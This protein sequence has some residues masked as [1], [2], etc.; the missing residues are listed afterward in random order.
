MRA[1]VDAAVSARSVLAFRLGADHCRCMA[2]EWVAPLA[3][4]VTGCAGVIFTWLTGHQSR[5]QA[6]DLAIRN[7]VRVQRETAARER[8]DAYIATLR[9]TNLDIQILSYREANNAAKLHEM[10]EVWPKGERYRL[11]MEASI[12]VDAF[13]SPEAVE[14]QRSSN[15]SYA[16]KNLE[17][18]RAHYRGFLIIA[19]KELGNLDLPELP[20]P[21]A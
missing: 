20:T 14:W 2:W 11:A 4:A 5:R 7:E 1:C 13:G 18:M 15:K 19:R 21:A 9:I 16:N 10:D 12:A 8:R 17:E 6:D 3:T